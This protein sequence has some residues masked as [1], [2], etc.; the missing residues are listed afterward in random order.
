MGKVF[1]L[2]VPAREKLVLLA[3][4]DH[5]RDD[6]TGCY[7]SIETLARKTSQSRRGVQKI[8]RRLQHYYGENDGLIAPSKVSRGGPRRSTEYTLTLANSE[9][10]S[11]FASTHDS[12]QPRTP[13]PATA[14]AGTPNRERQSAQQRTGFA[15]TIKNR[16]EPSLNLSRPSR[17]SFPSSVE[18][19]STKS[20]A[21]RRRKMI[22][23]IA[24]QAVKLLKAEPRKAYGDLKEEL[25]QWAANEEEIP[26]FDAWPGSAPPIDQA[27]TIAFERRKTA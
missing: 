17:R 16:H 19:Q 5:A 20:Q 7:P 21:Y 14:Y 12:T 11:Q 23:R 26:Y 3:M 27:I 4:A 24:D 1:A 25:K 9:R 2:D 10:G 22:D 6:G 18:N 13:E 15:R 8:L